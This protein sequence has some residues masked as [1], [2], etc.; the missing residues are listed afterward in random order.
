MDTTSITY[1]ANFNNPQKTPTLPVHSST[2]KKKETHSP[3]GLE[4]RDV[5][6][7]HPTHSRN[8]FSPTTTMT[9]T[10]ESARE[11]ARSKNICERHVGRFRMSGMRS[12][13]R[14]FP[15]RECRQTTCGDNSFSFFFRLSPRGNA[16]ARASR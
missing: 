5:D 8:S 1:T 4:S 2:T 13:A 16:R 15:A 7:G 11:L 12:L 9:Y 6:R 14:L 10:C 3:T